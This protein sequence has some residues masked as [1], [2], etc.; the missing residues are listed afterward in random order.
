MYI[1]KRKQNNVELIEAKDSFGKKIRYKKNGRNIN[2][3]QKHFTLPTSEKLVMDDFLILLGIF[4]AEGWTRIYE[5]KDRNSIDYNVSISVNKQRVKD[6]L[7]P[8]LKNLG[9]NYTE[10]KD[11]KWKIYNK[12]LTMY[13]KDFS[14][15][16]TNKFIP[17]WCFSLGETQSGI[18]LNSMLCG[19]GTT[20]N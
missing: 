6:M 15:G 16:A 3:H 4:L 14:P 11:E 10:T 1:Q 17:R 19:D 5:R 8:A 12:N 2:P 13:L 7:K 9:Y 18:L 20:T